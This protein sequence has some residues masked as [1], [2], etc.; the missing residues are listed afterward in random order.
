MSTEILARVQFAFTT[1]FHYIFP[2]LSIG[3][4]LLLVM[5]EGAWLRTKNPLY[6]QMAHFWT[7]VFALIFGIGVASGIVLEFEFGTNW[8]TYS[9]YVG[10][11]FGSALAAE[12]IF[13]FFLE[14]GFLA[15]LVFGWNKVS[16]RMHFFATCMV[17]LGSS[18]SAIWI[19]VANSWMQ[20][21]AGYKIVGD[22]MHARARITDFWAMVLNP[23]S[24][25]RLSHTVSAAYL[26]G[27]LLVT[28]VGAYY[29][30]KGRHEAFGRASVKFG[31]AVAGVA[32]VLQAV[33][34][35][36]SAIGVSR[37][38]PAKFAAMEGH[39]RTG[40]AD[41]TLLGYVDSLT[42]E[43]TGIKVPNMGSFML[44]F[45]ATKSVK[46]LDQIP[47]ENRPPLQLTFQMFHLMLAV[48]GALS[49]II[50]AAL[51]M[52]WRGTLWKCAP[53]LTV[54]SWAVILPQIGN[55]AGWIAAEVGRQPWI[56]YNMLR[57]SDALSKAVKANQILASLVMFIFLYALLFA[58]FVYLLDK[59]IKQ[60]PEEAEEAEP[61]GQIRQDVAE[62]IA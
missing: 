48:A 11:I 30:R 24:L 60:G 47:V 26:T 20:T 49:A 37:N 14:S 6:H 40:P 16:P 8:A 10:D 13:A 46:G 44:S 28:S 7:K 15:I 21:P 19:I 53:M 3:L 59:R 39:A 43:S 45:D 2:P 56:V 9:R 18:F 29:L 42:G 31:L 61:M 5:M 27:A 22:G 23:S 36:Q 25:D 32:L 55:Q 41:I 51:F 33:T 35:H 12:G 4:G 50:G 1:M 62:V 34:G 17:A 54:L 38:Q 58:L 57:T 52:W